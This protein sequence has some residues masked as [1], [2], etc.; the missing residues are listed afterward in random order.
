ME[1]F[2]GGDGVTP[3]SVSLD[4]ALSVIDVRGLQREAAK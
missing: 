4:G 3:R 2:I 1:R